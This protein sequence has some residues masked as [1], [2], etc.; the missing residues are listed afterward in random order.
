MKLLTKKLTYYWRNLLK[1]NEAYDREA[2][3]KENLKIS[4]YRFLVLVIA[5]IVIVA[6]FLFLD[7]HLYKG[8]KFQSFRYKSVFIH[9]FL[10]I[11]C[12]VYLLLYRGLKRSVINGRIT[13]SRIALRTFTFL[14]ILSGSMISLNSLQLTQNIHIYAVSTLVIACVYPYDPKYLI[15][16]FILNHGVFL[17][18]Y[19][20]MVED[21]FTRMANQINTTL[22]I[23]AAIFIVLI[24]Y[25]HR[26]TE[27][28]NQERLQK[29]EHNFKNL[30]FA[31]PLPLFL[32]AQHGGILFCNDQA[33]RFYGIGE[34][35][36]NSLGGEDLHADKVEWQE[37][38]G[39]LKSEGK[40][41]NRI[42]RHR[43]QEGQE[44]WVM[45][46]YEAIDYFGNP[47]ILC[48]VV[49]VTE[50]KKLQNQLSA[51]ASVDPLTGVLNRRKGMEELEGL[52]TKS[53]AEHKELALCFADIDNLKLINDQYGHGE[54]DRLI[55]LIC[56]LL[57][58]ELESE[59]IIFR[60]GGDEFIIV[61][62][63]CQLS[64]AENKCQRI[65]H[66][67]EAI[68]Q[69][70][71]HPYTMGFSFGLYPYHP[72]VNKG[73]KELIEMADQEMYLNKIRRG[74]GRVPVGFPNY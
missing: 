51:H 56:E 72:G 60:Y 24:L 41:H 9:M 10:F 26:V 17:T 8:P 34:G 2:F 49:D 4:L 55:T 1:V 58:N 15:P 39:Q 37:V 13:Y 65:L 73:A 22:T 48:G 71:M 19:S 46:N 14:A 54:G 31:N 35:Q 42:I 67:L 63:Q 44:K 7:F 5:V 45:A 69:Q 11:G 20:L 62:A 30:F 52:L 21:P 70:K 6:F 40:V 66:Q 68:N 12:A 23:L 29:K 32:V 36:L 59:D 25:R 27:A 57:K 28:I 38:L 16:A 47:A 64:E 33:M 3:R 74:R 50:M 61:F 43:T 18:A 53:K